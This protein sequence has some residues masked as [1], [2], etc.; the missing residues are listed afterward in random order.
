M[1]RLEGSSRLDLAREV[2]L[3]ANVGRGLE[4]LPNMPSGKLKCSRT[5]C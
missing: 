4:E 5:R 3:M 2:E 1:S